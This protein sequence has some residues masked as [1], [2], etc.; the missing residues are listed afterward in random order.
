MSHRNVSIHHRKAR[1]SVLMSTS[2]TA[3]GRSAFHIPVFSSHANGP[4]CLKTAVPQRGLAQR[5]RERTH[6]TSQSLRLHR[7]Y[8]RSVLP[9]AVAKERPYFFSEKLAMEALFVTLDQ[10]YSNFFIKGPLVNFIQG[11]WS[12][13][14]PVKC[15]T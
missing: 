2:R 5:T 10:G 9:P 15:M 1:I 12:G 7:R 6:L 11:Q 14:M 8:R 3:R 13:T 4:L